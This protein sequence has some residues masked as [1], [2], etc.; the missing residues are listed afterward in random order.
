MDSNKEPNP[1]KGMEK[2]F[3]GMLFVKPITAIT[4]A[5]EMISEG[6]KY[7]K[8]HKNDEDY[9]QTCFEAGCDHDEYGR[10]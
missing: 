3:L 4:G 1:L 5:V 2:M 9:D 8:I 10:L 6:I 7:H